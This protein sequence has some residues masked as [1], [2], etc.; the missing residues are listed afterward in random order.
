M[1]YRLEELIEDEVEELGVYKLDGVAEG[2]DDEL[3]GWVISR[4]D[5]LCEDVDEIVEEVVV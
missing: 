4:T 3:V 1:K 2:E 5:G